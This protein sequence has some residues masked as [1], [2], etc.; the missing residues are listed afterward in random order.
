MASRSSTATRSNRQRLEE[1]ATNDANVASRCLAPLRCAAF[2]VFV[3]YSTH[4]TKRS[5]RAR[6]GALPGR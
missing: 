4:A 3:I 1:F 5:R 2:I 6:R